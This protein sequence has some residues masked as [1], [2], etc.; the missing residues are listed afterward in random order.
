MKKM[1]ADIIIVAAGPAGLAAAITAGENGKKVLVFEKSNTTGGA[2]NMGMGLLGI[3][4]KVQKKQFNNISV[5]YALDKHMKYTHYRADAELVGAYF[6]LSADTIEWLEDM[7]VEFAGAFRYDRTSE[8]TWHVVKP[9]TGEPGPRAAGTMTKIMTERARELGAEFHLETPVTDLLVEDGKVVGVTA[10]DASGEEIEARAKAVIVCTGGFG[11]NA[12]MLKQELGLELGKDVYTFM[13]PGIT[14]DG[15]RMMWNAGAQKFGA[16][17]EILFKNDRQFDYMP[18][19][20]M[21][22]QGNLVINL[23]GDRFM[24]EADMS[25]TTFAGNAIGMQPGHCC[26]SIIDEGVVRYYKKNGFDFMSLVE[27][28]EHVPHFDAT[29]KQALEDGYPDLVVAA[30]LEELSEKLGIDTEKLTETIEDY[31]DYCETG[32]DEKFFKEAQYLKP[33]TGKGRYLALRF[34]MA[35]YG[36]IGGVRI[37]KRCEVL[38]SEFA[39]IPG[40]YCCGQDANTIYGDSYN[41]TLPGNSMGFA[42]NTGRMAADAASDFAD[43]N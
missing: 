29:V 37:N 21:F 17:L 38:D 41:F 4:T 34:H 25:N 13:I 15:L 1:E 28:D 11:T 27:S 43:D 20:G 5:A 6:A 16:N 26:W 18:L 10:K 14:G 35:A 33:V 39:S 30:T 23:L 3:D 22:R 36:T 42:V 2:A 12:E 8:A 24:N 40:L 19:A 32:R 31:N 7:G 9:E